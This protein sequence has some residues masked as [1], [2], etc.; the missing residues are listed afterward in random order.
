MSK[1]S[2]SKVRRRSWKRIRRQSIWLR[3]KIQGLEKTTAHAQLQG[4]CRQAGAAGRSSSD[5]WTGLL[6][7]A[8]QARLRQAQQ[9]GE[10]LAAS[11]E[12]RV[13]GVSDASQDKSVRGGKEESVTHEAGESR[14]ARRPRITQASDGCSPVRA[15]GNW[16][17]SARR[18]G[19]FGVWCA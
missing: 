2:R 11:W 13:Q 4:R 14:G 8:R 3:R 9:D 19:A 6:Y 18:V 17:N 7:V 5:S 1:S 12:T 10:D 15:G 16:D